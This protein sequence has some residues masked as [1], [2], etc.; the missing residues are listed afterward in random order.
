ITRRP[1]ALLKG[2][3]RFPAVTVAQNDCIGCKRCMG[4]GCPAITME[5]G[6][7]SVDSTLCVGCGLCMSLCPKKAIRASK[8]GVS[9]E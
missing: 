6:K 5:N 1:C 4:I 8:E 3:K 2:V 9:H 7:A